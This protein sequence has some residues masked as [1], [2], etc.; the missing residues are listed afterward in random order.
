MRRY[1]VLVGI[2]IEINYF[3]AFAPIILQV[4]LLWLN[5]IPVQDDNMRGRPEVCLGRI[6]LS[7]STPAS[8]APRQATLPHVNEDGDGLV[9]KLMAF[10]PL[11]PSSWLTGLLLLFLLPSLCCSSVINHCRFRSRFM[12]TGWLSPFL[13]TTDANLPLNCGVGILAML[14]PFPVQT[15]SFGWSMN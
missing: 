8:R 13:P 4:S 12:G 5:W 1:T 15:L 11:F 6:R 7:H 2:G 10:L 9:D 3:T 14:S